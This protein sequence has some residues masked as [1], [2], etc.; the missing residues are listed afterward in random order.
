MGGAGAPQERLGVVVEACTIPQ[1]QGAE[2][3]PVGGVL[4]GIRRRGAGEGAQG[5]GGLGAHAASEATQEVVSHRVGLA[6]QGLT[7]ERPGLPPHGDAVAD[8]EVSPT[9]Q[10]HRPG[11]RGGAELAHLEDGPAA[12]N[13]DH[14]APKLHRPVEERPRRAQARRGEP[15]AQG[16][17]PG[18]EP[19]EAPLTHGQGDQR[20][21][22]QGQE[23]VRRVG[24]EP[25]PQH[26]AQG[27]EQAR[28]QQRRG[29]GHG[30]AL[31]KVYAKART[32]RAGST[33]AV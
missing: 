1:G 22:A 25:R 15:Q 2:Q 29:A 18:G 24:L 4:E 10:L 17:G 31:R 16:R 11:E 19:A 5:E 21:G 27:G 14:L 32:A 26:H 23:R 6:G 9:A 13:L 3:A 33:A 7:T 8:A 20:Q 28:D 12:A 30:P